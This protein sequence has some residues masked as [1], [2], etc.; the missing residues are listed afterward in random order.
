MVSFRSRQKRLSQG[1]DL[2]RLHGRAVALWKRYSRRCA[3]DEGAMP[4]ALMAR[5][6]AAKAARF[7]NESDCRRLH[8]TDALGTDL[9]IEL[10]ENP[11]LGGRGDGAL[12][13]RHALRCRT[14]DGG[15]LPRLPKARRHVKRKAVAT[16]PLLATAAIELFSFAEGK[17]VSFH[18]EK[19]GASRAGRA[20]LPWTRRVV[21][22][23]S[24]VPVQI[25]Q[26]RNG[27][28]TTRFSTK[29]RVPSCARKSPSN[30]ASRRRG[31]GQRD[32]RT[33]RRQRFPVTCG[34]MVGSGDL[35]LSAYAAAMERRYRSF[36]MNFA[37]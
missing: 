25:P 18:A 13:Y 11:H 2:S 7:L 17:V 34:F 22:R 3:S 24:R 36:G 33:A 10:P 14:Y 32:A 27:M 5:V 28:Y 23:R 9:T 1:K 12:G 35:S 6:Y 37:F 30:D 15:D 29:M 26:I 16:K 4:C 21:S 19:G 31:Y 8:Y 20:F